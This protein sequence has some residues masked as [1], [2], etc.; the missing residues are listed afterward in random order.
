ML[1]AAE[2]MR[3]ITALS[4]PATPDGKPARTIY[5]GVLPLWRIRLVAL[6]NPNELKDL[7]EVELKDREAADT[8][9][10]PTTKPT[11]PRPMAP[12]P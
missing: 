5:G 11:T 4:R 7:Q 12:S 2:A 8:L 3:K 6:Y 1:T 9:L 10:K